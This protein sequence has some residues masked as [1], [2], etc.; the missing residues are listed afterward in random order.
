MVTKDCHAITTVDL[1]DATVAERS[2][3]KR[4]ALTGLMLVTR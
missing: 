3:L 1:R 2:Y 4:M